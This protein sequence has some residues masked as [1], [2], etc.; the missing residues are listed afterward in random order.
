MGVFISSER[1]NLA[2][3]MNRRFAI[4]DIGNSTLNLLDIGQELENRSDNESSNSSDIESD[5]EMLT[6]PS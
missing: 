6:L 1:T 3:N 2:P 4:T 5:S